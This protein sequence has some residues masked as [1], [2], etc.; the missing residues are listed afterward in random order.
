MYS[1]YPGSILSDN[2]A[3]PI[4]LSA[5]NRL[6]NITLRLFQTGVLQIG[7]YKRDINIAEIRSKKERSEQFQIL[8]MQWFDRV[9]NSR[10]HREGQIVFGRYWDD[11]IYPIILEIM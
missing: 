7:R 4:F 5:S 6:D 8:S 10:N 9:L 11:V 3:F 1:R 2:D